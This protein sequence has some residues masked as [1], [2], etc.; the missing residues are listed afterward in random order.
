M[1]VDRTPP[2]KVRL[3][4]SEPDGDN[5]WFVSQPETGPSVLAEDAVS[6]LKSTYYRH[7]AAADWTVYSR[8]FALLEGEHTISYYAEDKAGNKSQ[9]QTFTYRADFSDPQGGITAP[10]G[11]GYFRVNM[12]AEANC[13]DAVSGWPRLPGSRMERS[14]LARGAGGPGYLGSRTG[15]TLVAEVRDEGLAAPPCS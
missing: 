3:Q 12:E 14:R 15:S 4:I 10:A 5:G 11:G 7:D 13:R 9:V 8:P 2:A 1:I 6:G